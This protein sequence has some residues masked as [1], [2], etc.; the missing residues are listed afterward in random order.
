MDG[1]MDG[2]LVDG[3]MGGWICDGKWW[4][5]AGGVG[6]PIHACSC[7][8]LCVHVFVC[9]C[10]CACVVRDHMGLLMRVR[11]RESVRVVV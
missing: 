5:G 2:W 11:V 6:W 1:W 4:E 3:W 8:C 10:S 9:T 7:A